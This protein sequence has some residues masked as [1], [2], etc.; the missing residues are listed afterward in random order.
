M[1]LPESMRNATKTGNSL[2]RLS[3]RPQLVWIIQ[4]IADQRCIY[5]LRVSQVSCLAVTREYKPNLVVY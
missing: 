1:V 3:F 2:R 4:S 5:P